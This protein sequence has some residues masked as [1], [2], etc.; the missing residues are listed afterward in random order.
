M[1]TVARNTEESNRFISPL[2]TLIAN[3]A[4]L[5]H[6]RLQWGRLPH[7]FTIGHSAS[8]PTA[9]AC[10]GINEYDQPRP[11]RYK[12]GFGVFRRGNKNKARTL[13]RTCRDS[14][15]YR[16]MLHVFPTD[17]FAQSPTAVVIKNLNSLI[18]YLRSV[19]RGV[20]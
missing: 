3:A 6:D 15:R 19:A 18:R 20:A 17:H 8:I 10:Q 4:A 11:W 16:P 14:L 9:G 13:R 5:G 2:L 7:E 12:A 1:P